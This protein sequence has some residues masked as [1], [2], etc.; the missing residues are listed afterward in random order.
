MS[1]RDQPDARVGDEKIS[2]RDAQKGGQGAVGSKH[3]DVQL[4]PKSENADKRRGQT[5]QKDMETRKCDRAAIALP[6]PARQNFVA[7]KP[8]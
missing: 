5:S 8:A 2:P 4:D 6:K 7:D 3:P 1:E